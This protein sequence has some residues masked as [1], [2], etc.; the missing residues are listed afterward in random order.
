MRRSLI[1]RKA[2][3]RASFEQ[4]CAK[5]S[6]SGRGVDPGGCRSKSAPV[7]WGRFSNAARTVFCVSRCEAMLDKGGSST[8]SPSS[9][10][11]VLRRGGITV[12]R[13]SVAPQVSNP[14]SSCSSR[15]ARCS[16]AH[17]LGE[18]CCWRTV[19]GAA[20]QDSGRGEKLRL[21]SSQ[22]GSLSDSSSSFSYRHRPS[23]CQ[24][25]C[26]NMPQ[27]GFSP[28]TS[29]STLIAPVRSNLQEHT[30]V[31]PW[32]LREVVSL[33]HESAQATHRGLLARSRSSIRPLDPSGQVVL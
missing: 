29:N 4:T 7:H 11:K 2:T 30:F 6:D 17:G 28:R 19:A 9:S 12:T 27:I 33:E 31:T 14:P 25:S 15:L 22:N 8:S 16:A 26:T 3:V 32:P 18:A 5:P 24:R 20:A 10:R 1:E 21:K 13:T 23:A